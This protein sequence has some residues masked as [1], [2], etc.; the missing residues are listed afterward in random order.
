M[1]TD[2][3]QIHC[4]DR[5][6]C[7]RL[8]SV[9]AAYAACI[10]WSPRDGLIASAGGDRQVH[11]YNASDGSKVSV[12]AGHQDAVTGLGFVPDSDLL[13]SASL[14]ATMRL[15]DTTA[16]AAIGEPITADGPID[17]IRLSAD[18]HTL[19]TGYRNCLL[20]V[21][22]VAERRVERGK[23]SWFWEVGP[24]SAFSFSPDGKHLGIGGATG[25]FCVIDLT[26]K[27]V[28]Y[29]FSGRRV[30]ASSVTYSPDGG[31]LAV[32]SPEGHLTFWNL[33]LWQTQTIEGAPL[34]AV[35]SMA[36]SHD[37][38]SLAIATDD[39]AAA[40]CATSDESGNSPTV[41]GSALSAGLT[42]PQRDL[43]RRP[44]DRSGPGFRLWDVA[45][46]AERFAPGQCC[47]STPIPIVTWSRQG[48]LAAGSNDGTVWIWH[49]DQ[50]SLVMR[51]AAGSSNHDV[52]TWQPQTGRP[53]TDNRLL[54]QLDPV[55]ALD[56]S[57]SG[58]TLA[59]ATRSGMIQLVGGERWSDRVK[60]CSDAVDVA[61]LRFTASGEALAA[62]RRG[63][64]LWWD[65]REPDSIGAATI[66]GNETD[67][68]ICSI[69]MAHHGAK[70]A[71]GRESGIAQ[72]VDFDLPL[73]H[74]SQL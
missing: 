11:L 66:I 29:T 65:L 10:A 70:L 22:K 38:R 32:V 33:E 62:N 14:D 39:T 52:S 50:G 53:P 20:S 73:P 47:T 44:W 12:L 34:P 49:P 23:D 37:G 56:F 58:E 45:T 19:V 71:I 26:T 9:G 28:L 64:L 63:T 51:F 13:I 59:V 25:K 6:T 21:W 35:R 24:R 68:R 61:C 69:A 60:L 43:A 8:W 48:T 46:G 30:G 27:E 18:G 67:S 3:E 57:P 17:Q 36:F 1:T 42:A 16:H 31:K 74:G 5:S 72:L 54:N 7:A 55:V 40:A 2:G 15:W 4:W 41:R